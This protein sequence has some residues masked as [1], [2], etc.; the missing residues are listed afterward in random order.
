[1]QRRHTKF[2]KVRLLG[3]RAK[4]IDNGSMPKCPVLGL[5]SS[6][7][8]ATREYEMGCDL[9]TDEFIPK[10]VEKNYGKDV[11][12]HIHLESINGIVFC[13]EC[14]LLKGTN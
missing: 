13:R 8:I 6:I 14:G 3:I 4:Q 7:D 2:E 5:T 11:C 12:E 9:E 1:M 10:P